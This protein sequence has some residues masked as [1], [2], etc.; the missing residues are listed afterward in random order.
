VLPIVTARGA[1]GHAPVVAQRVTRIAVSLRRRGRA[2]QD[3]AGRKKR[4]GDQTH[5]H[6]PWCCREP[7]AAGPEW[8]ATDMDVTLGAELK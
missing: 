1:R 7:F 5:E 8:G 4:E 3:E 2:R 6:L